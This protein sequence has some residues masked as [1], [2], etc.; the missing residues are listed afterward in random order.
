M[1]FI[2]TPHDHDKQIILP[3]DEIIHYHCWV[4]SRCKYHENMKETETLG[5]WV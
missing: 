3:K 2:V 5:S 4:N 1:E